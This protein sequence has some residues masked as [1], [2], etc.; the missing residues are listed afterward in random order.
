MGIMLSMEFRSPG[1][2]FGT[3]GNTYYN[4]GRSKTLHIIQVHSGFNRSTSAR[5]KIKPKLVAISLNLA[6]RQKKFTFIGS[7]VCEPRSGKQVN[8][9]VRPDVHLCFSPSVYT[10]QSNREFGLIKRT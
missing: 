5:S 10:H 4:Q 9:S 6:N 1:E 2:L 7:G 3:L 8:V